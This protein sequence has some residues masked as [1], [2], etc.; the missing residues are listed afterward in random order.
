MAIVGLDHC[1]IRTADLDASVVFY[2]DILGLRRGERPAFLFPG[3]WLYCGST[4]VVHLVGEP[5]AVAGGTGVVDH[6]AFCTNDLEGIKRNL[7]SHGIPFQERAVPGG[8][9]NQVFLQDPDGVT[10]ELNF[11][12]Q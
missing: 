4:P 7:S 6:I 5:S 11:Q 2:E 1:T 12:R 8:T 3:A 10:I 9:V